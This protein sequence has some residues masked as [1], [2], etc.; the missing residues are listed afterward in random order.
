MKNKFKGLFQC[1]N[2]IKNLLKQTGFSFLFKIIAMG[3]NFLLVPLTLSYLGR[4]QYGIWMTLLTV[5]SWMSFCDFGLGNGMRNKVTVALAQ[6]NL[7][8]VR[9]YISSTYFSILFLMFILVGSLTIIEPF[10]NWQSFFNT[11]YLEN[12]KLAMVGISVFILMSINFVLSLINQVANAYQQ[13]SLTVLNQLIGNLFAFFFT[14]IVIKT[15]Q[16]ELFL[17]AFA[18]AFSLV[19]S[20]VIISIYFYK[21]NSNIIPRVKYFKWS[22]VKELSGLSFRFFVIQIAALVFFA[23]DNFIITQVLG[24]EYV[25]PYNI[26]F[27][28]FNVILFAF[29]IL[30]TPLWS[31]L[32]DAYASNDIKW[33]KK[34][35]K[36]MNLLMI[37][38]C[39]CVFFLCILAPTIFK[40]WIG[41][42][43]NHI[44]PLLI[45]LMGIFTILSV[46]NNIYGVFLNATGKLKL[47]MYSTI[48]II[49]VNIPL[50]IYLGELYGVVGVLLT[51]IVCMLPGAIIEPI[52]Y[53]IILKE[54]NLSIT[55]WKY[56]IFCE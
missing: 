25:T 37:P 47:S 34:T 28:Y 33:I 23:K 16:D 22:T 7:D 18:Y 55:D 4:E 35:M 51:T 40:I 19:L 54:K 12:A 45:W 48:L 8:A 56:K 41:E 14:Y 10:L 43:A 29:G 38:L 44:E 27:K 26:T 15:T 11:I 52:Q 36:T 9:E 5:L 17:V 46:W 31:A 3:C 30:T 32:G 1:E 6:K 20:N 42:E 49:A 2:R 53:C 39:I 50:A 21:T 24:P 13:S